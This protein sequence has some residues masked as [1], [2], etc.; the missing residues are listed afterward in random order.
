MPSDGKSS[1][2]LW[3]GELKIVLLYNFFL[4]GWYIHWNNVF[5]IILFDSED[6]FF[7]IKFYKSK[8]IN[9]TKQDNNNHF[10]N[11]KYKCKQNN[12]IKVKKKIC[13]KQLKL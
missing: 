10:S 11:E 8:K 13:V 7:K 1:H 12:S 2:C 9:R 5:S 3:Q 6:L 4:Y